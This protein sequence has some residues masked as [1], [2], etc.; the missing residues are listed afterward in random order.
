MSLLDGLAEQLNNPIY[1]SIM[2]S[3]LDDEFD[4]EF[5]LEAASEKNDIEFS[6]KD[7]DAILNDDNPDNIA[8]DLTKN[9]ESE[10]KIEKDVIEDTAL[11]AALEEFEGVMNNLENA[12]ESNNEDCCNTDPEEIDAANENDTDDKVSTNDSSQGD[13]SEYPED[14]VVSIESLLSMLE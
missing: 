10:S 6:Q 14:E 4:F 3:M 11:E 7:I 2:E 12:E 8:A 13:G 1:T 5:A 9:D